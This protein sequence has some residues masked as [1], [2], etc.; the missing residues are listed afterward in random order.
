MFTVA[1]YKNWYGVYDPAG[2]LVCVCVYRKGAQSAAQ[3]LNVLHNSAKAAKIARAYTSS[4]ETTTK[5]AA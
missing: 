1:G 3:Y 2:A 5:G 4:T